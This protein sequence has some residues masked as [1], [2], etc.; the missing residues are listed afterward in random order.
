MRSA[1]K[2][3]SACARGCR[4]NDDVVAAFGNWHA[5][6]GRSGVARPVAELSAGADRRLAGLSRR[7][8]H[9]NF[10]WPTSAVAALAFMKANPRL[11]RFL[12]VALLCPGICPRK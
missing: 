2:E 11:R 5:L 3:G 10:P 7:S 4:G 1:L 9:Y 8:R 6:D 12:P